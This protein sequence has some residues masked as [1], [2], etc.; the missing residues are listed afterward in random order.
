MGS[1]MRFFICSVVLCLLQIE[2]GLA[3]GQGLLW[4]IQGK[5]TEAYLFGTIHSE[6]K[7]VTQ[8]PEP[9]E[10]SFNAADILMLE[11]SLDQ[12][13]SLSV[14][15]R[16]MLDADGSLTKQVGKPLA[17]EAE[18]A[19]RSRG[20]P[21]QVTDLMQPWAVVM[22]LSAPRQVTG[23][24]LDKQLYER[25]MAAGKQ[26]Q[27]LEKP[28]EQL[29]VFT[30]LTL[31]EQKSLLRHVLDEYRTYPRMY[32]RLTEA[33]LARD[34][35]TLAE[36]SFANPI[37][38]DPALQE[39]FMAQML[40]GRNHRMLERMEPFLNQGKVFIAVGALHLV[41]DEGLIA[42]LRQRGYEVKSIY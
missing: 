40:T 37:S 24:F 3:D 22:I 33:Y 4:H 19:M 31:D 39:K 26:F 11:M 29:S 8:L 16:M 7:R 20:I 12:M 9:V 36:I 41:G 25:A 18:V 2:I 15:A 21:P 13:T 42:L 32:E 17:E 27:P 14:A 6:D 28:D 34:L 5:G 38:E 1:F 35:D 23:L 10:N 30:S